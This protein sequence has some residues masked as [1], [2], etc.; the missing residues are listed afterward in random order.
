[1]PKRF[2]NG[3][4]NRRPTYLRSYARCLREVQT[5]R[6]NDRHYETCGVT[7]LQAWGT[8]EMKD[9][10][11]TLM[12]APSRG[13]CALAVSSAQRARRR[14]T[15]PG[16]MPLFPTFWKGGEIAAALSLS[17]AEAKS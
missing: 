10:S 11:R 6:L 12:I 3:S 9:A 13:A 2:A 7:E 14:W 4:C 5:T 8:G 1:L 16:V 17:P 15:E